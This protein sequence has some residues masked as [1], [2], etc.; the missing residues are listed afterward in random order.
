MDGRLLPPSIDEISAVDALLGL[1]EAYKRQNGRPPVELS[2][3]DPSDTFTSTYAERIKLPALEEPFRYRLPFQIGDIDVIQQKLGRSQPDCQILITENG[4]NAGLAAANALALSGVKRIAVV[5]PCY[6]ATPYTLRRCG[7]ETR[8]IY[9]QR[10]SEFRLPHVSLAPDEA[11]WIESPIFG[12]GV[13]ADSQTIGMLERLLAKGHYVVL[14][15]AL[16]P[17]GRSIASALGHLKTL[18]SIHAPHK[19]VSL[20]GFKFGAAVFHRDHSQTFDHWSDVLNGGLSLSAVAASRYFL[21]T[22]FDHYASLVNA[23]CHQ[24][25]GEIAALLDAVE[26]V[27]TDAEA[28][29]PWRT[30]Y[31]RDLPA[32]LGL[33]RNWIATLLD[34]SGAVMIP[35]IQSGCSPA[36]GFCFRVN[37]LR[38]DPHF[39]AALRRLL[40][41][42]SLQRNPCAP[43]SREAFREVLGVRR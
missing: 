13:A 24:V 23:H 7:I 27:T 26:G 31:V 4:T 42:L 11:V 9:W 28:A 43:R 8:R 20:N 33:D 10:T 1:A 3:W 36:W 32:R 21:S 38:Y 34:Q 40:D 39:R 41:A 35:G 5:S 16:A 19:T 2:H 15:E 6:F 18:I 37:L 30:L 17:P 29:G 25:S 12:T 22:E 14:D